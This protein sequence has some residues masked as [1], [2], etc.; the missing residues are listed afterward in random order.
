MTILWCG[1]EEMDFPIGAVGEFK[2]RISW[3]RLGRARDRVF[4]IVISDP[5]K[6]VLVNAYYNAE[7]G[8][9]RR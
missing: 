5:I 3:E 7:L 9:S 8:T 6:V 2:R 1:G 4:K